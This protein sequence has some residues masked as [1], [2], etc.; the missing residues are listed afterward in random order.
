MNIRDKK[1]SEICKRM[2]SEKKEKDRKKEKKE[3]SSKL[4]RKIR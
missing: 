1:N 2:G 4:K 3:G